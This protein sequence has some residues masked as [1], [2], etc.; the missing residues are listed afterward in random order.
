MAFNFLITLPVAIKTAGG[1]EQKEPHG[2]TGKDSPGL[3]LNDSPLH[4]VVNTESA[5]LQLNN[6]RN[7]FAG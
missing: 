6:T 5:L 1:R 7:D 3:R 4:F 2:L